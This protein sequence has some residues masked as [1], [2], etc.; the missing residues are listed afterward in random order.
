MTA[1]LLHADHIIPWVYWIGTEDDYNNSDNLACACIYCNSIKKEHVI[2]FD[3]LTNTYHPLYDPRD[4][5]YVWNDHFSWSDDYEQ[6]IAISSI[7]RAT[8]FVLQMNRPMYA[9]QRQL[10]RN[11]WRGGDDV[12][13]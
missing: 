8:M 11:A 1:V 10:P 5:Q 6:I 3:V 12:W 2:G 13:P 4:S 7:G 9:R